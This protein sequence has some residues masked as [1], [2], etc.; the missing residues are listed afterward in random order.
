MRS[1]FHLAFDVRDPDQ[2]KGFRSLD[3]VFAT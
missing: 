3:A 1:I 2:V